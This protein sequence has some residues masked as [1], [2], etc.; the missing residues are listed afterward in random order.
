MLPPWRQ[1]LGARGS[2]GLRFGVAD[3]VHV[4]EQPA[5]TSLALDALQTGVHPGLSVQLQ[6]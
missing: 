2:G 5:G 1:L 3:L 6:V 4:P